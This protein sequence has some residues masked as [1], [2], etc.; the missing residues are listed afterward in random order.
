MP[1]D[2][3]GDLLVALTTG[4]EPDEPG[5]WAIEALRLP[6]AWCLMTRGC[7]A[8]LTTHASGS[9]H[10][11]PGYELTFLVPRTEEDEEEPPPWAVGRLIELCR[12][13][14]LTGTR[15][16]PGSLVRVAGGRDQHPAGSTELPAI[17]LVEDPALTPV[18]CDQGPV[19]FL[20]AVG[21]TAEER[22]HAQ[23]SGTL[24]AVTSLILPT[25]P[26]LMTPGPAGS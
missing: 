3:E 17:A 11:A 4:R 18:T 20:R 6:E 19:A 9:E 22:R 13:I 7:S 1:E 2:W 25:N 23:E 21:L 16:G 12:Y 5:V 24:D 14:E 10:S 26:E 8:L 15:I